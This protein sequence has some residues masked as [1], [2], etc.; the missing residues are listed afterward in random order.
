M[1]APVRLFDRRLYDFL[2]FGAAVSTIDVV[3]PPAGGTSLRRHFRRLA[4][5]ESGAFGIHLTN[6]GK[7]AETGSF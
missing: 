2:A 7:A 4:G 1:I 5:V 3:A 6:A